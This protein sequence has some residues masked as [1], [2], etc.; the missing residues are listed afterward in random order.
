MVGR[1]RSEPLMESL[2]SFLAK[3]A[4]RGSW[5]GGGSA[6]ALT[7]A[8]AAALLEKLIVRQDIARQLRKSRRECTRLIDQDAKTFARVVDVM[9]TGQRQ[10]F[11]R[12]LKQAIDVPCRVYERACAIRSIG[13]AAQRLDKPQ[14]RSDLR[15][16]MAL[17]DAAGVSARELIDT[18]LTWLKDP[19][20]A[21]AIRRRL[22]LGA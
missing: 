8:L 18:N 1:G 7:A 6:A 16:A 2:E 22:Q 13:H 19:V 14:L 9:R 11:T 5:F 17:A 3:V 10:E 21:R 12:A 20:Y 15:C 4:R